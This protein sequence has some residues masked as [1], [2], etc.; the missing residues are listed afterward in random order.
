MKA[1][2]STVEALYH[3]SVSCSHPIGSVSVDKTRKRLPG[4]LEPF[5]RDN[6]QIHLHSISK[7]TEIRS[8]TGTGSPP[9]TFDPARNSHTFNPDFYELFCTGLSRTAHVLKTCIVGGGVKFHALAVLRG[10]V[11]TVETRVL[12]N[13]VRLRFA[14]TEK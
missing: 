13:I 11:T 7:S 10:K 5:E 2:W 12:L 8:V 1:I 3:S 9:P 14:S 4:S 6:L